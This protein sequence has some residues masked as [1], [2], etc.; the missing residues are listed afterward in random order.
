MINYS[1]NTIGNKKDYNRFLER[2]LE[3]RRQN[4]HLGYTGDF[5]LVTD[6]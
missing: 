5:R 2:V 6:I 3:C 4:R 1:L